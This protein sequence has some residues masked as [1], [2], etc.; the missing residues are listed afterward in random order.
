MALSVQTVI[1]YIIEAIPTAVTPPDGADDI[2]TV[3]IFVYPAPLFDTLI[4]LREPDSMNV[5]IASAVFPTPTT[6]RD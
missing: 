1:P 5:V 6:V 4:V 3:G 2:P